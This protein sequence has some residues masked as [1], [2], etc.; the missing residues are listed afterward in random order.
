MGDN[1]EDDEF[2]ATGGQTFIKGGNRNRAG[3]KGA[4][5]KKASAAKGQDGS[6][7]NQQINTKNSAS[8]A[9][10]KKNKKTK[11]AEGAQ[12]LF[13]EIA[14]EDREEEGFDNGEGGESEDDDDDDGPGVTFRTE[15]YE[16]IGGP[17]ATGDKGGVRKG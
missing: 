5:S 10:S 15:D 14:M 4:A 6:A 8:K 12:A 17:M 3:R 11:T 13:D 1:D 7:A 16:G 2:A 9:K